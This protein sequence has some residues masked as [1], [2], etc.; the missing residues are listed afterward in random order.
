MHTLRT[1]PRSQPCLGGDLTEHHHHTGLGGGLARDLRG[2]GRGRN[3]S[4]AARSPA[5]S[6][7]WEKHKQGNRVSRLGSR[8]G[9]SSSDV[10]A[11]RRVRPTRSPFDRAGRAFREPPA[12]GGRGVRARLTRPLPRRVETRSRPLVHARHRAG[13]ACREKRFGSVSRCFRRLD[14]RSSTRPE[15]HLGVGILGEAGIEDTVGDLWDGVGRM[16]RQRSVRNT[17]R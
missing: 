15:T 11:A 17:S 14:G 5:T 12:T 8:S 10:S 4:A 1:Q 7:I 13:R 2:S 16:S 9:R 6:A 3:A